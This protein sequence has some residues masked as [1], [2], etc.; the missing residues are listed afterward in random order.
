MRAS[1]DR[2]ESLRQIEQRIQALEHYEKEIL[3]W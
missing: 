2:A 3:K 1:T